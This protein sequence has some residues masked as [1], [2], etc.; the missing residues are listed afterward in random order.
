MPL[1]RPWYLALGLQV[2]ALRLLEFMEASLEE[3]AATLG[4]DCRERPCSQ[5][6]KPVGAHQLPPPPLPWALTVER[7]G[8]PVHELEELPGRS[9]H[10]LFAGPAVHGHLGEGA[11]RG[12]RDF[13]PNHEG[14]APRLRLLPPL[15]PRRPSLT[16]PQS[17]ESSGA[18]AEV[19]QPSS[20]PRPARPRRRAPNP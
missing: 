4:H 9:L 3:T 18:R 2:P 17:A 7:R 16:G 19:S 14:T 10:R 8:A 15:A 13:H 1:P 12:S 20:D 5:R 6:C 11:L